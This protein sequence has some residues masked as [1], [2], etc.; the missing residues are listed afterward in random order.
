MY[1]ANP[2]L[3]YSVMEHWS[4]LTKPLYT[5]HNNHNI[6]VLNKSIQAMVLLYTVNMIFA[7]QK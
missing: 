1:V 2:S 4:I 3:Y 5:Q 7:N 6:F